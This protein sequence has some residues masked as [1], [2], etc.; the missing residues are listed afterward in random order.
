MLPMSVSTSRHYD[1]FIVIAIFV[2]VSLL[3]VITVYNSQQNTTTGSSQ[4]GLVKGV[5]TTSPAAI[6]SIAPSTDGAKAYIDRAAEAAKSGD[7][8]HAANVLSDGIRAYPDD[9]NLVLTRE[10]YENEALRH[11]Q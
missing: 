6:Q 5:A 8:R 7:Y 3:A 9:Q 1:S 4:A 10:Y 2:L 11:G